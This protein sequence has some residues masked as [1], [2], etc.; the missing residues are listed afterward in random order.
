MDGNLLIYAYENLK[1]QILVKS[2]IYAEVVM[3]N[4]FESW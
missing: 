4:N 1:Y 2:D 3:L